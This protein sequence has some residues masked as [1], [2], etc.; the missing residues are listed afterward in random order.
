MPNLLILSKKAD[1]YEA[2]VRAEGLPE[3]EIYSSRHAGVEAGIAGRCELVLGQPDLIQA[4]LPSLTNL[5]W[6]QSTWAGVEPL[7]EAPAR[8]DYVLTNARGI[9]GPQMSEYVFG[10]LLAHE[11]QMWE[12]RQSQLAR[13]WAPVE[14]G[15]LRNRTIGL[16]GVGSIGA[17]LAGTA[18][19]FG[20]NVRGYTRSSETCPE[21]DAY[22]HGE[23][24]LTFADGLDYLV[25]SLP[26]TS[27][28]GRLVGK[29]LFEILPSHAIFIN[30]GRGSAVD[31]GAL[32]EA[33]RSKQ[34]AG[35]VLD[36]FEAEPL[37][38]SSPLWDLPNVFITF[39]TAAVTFP[40]D[41]VR[42]FFENYALYLGD[43]PLKYV[44]DFELGY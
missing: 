24:L 39:H 44:V 25:C 11:R 5:R 29:S 36:V 27:D 38:E 28:T 19:H 8:R 13:H 7:L 42:L 1:Q 22:Y 3:L 33:L 16:L 12:H 10:Y 41:M 34:I 4:L 37:P 6:A 15:T 9:F 2:L 20:M 26:D 40:T 32:V 35:A 30:V 23:D 17:H 31:E 21:I 14:G 18:H 43:E